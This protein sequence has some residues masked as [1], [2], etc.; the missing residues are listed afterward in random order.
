MKWSETKTLLTPL[1]MIT[2]VFAVSACG[3]SAT[4]DDSGVLP[5][6]S[7]EDCPDGLSCQA[8]V[9]AKDN[10]ECAFDSDCD[11]GKECVNGTC[12]QVQSDGGTDGGTDGGVDAGDQQQ[13][14]GIIEVDPVEID[15]GNG[16]IGDTVTQQLTI[17]N[18]GTADLRVF[19][20]TFESG[21][22][23]EFSAEPLGSVNQL[24]SPSD[25]L[26]V[27]V[28]Y[29]PTNASLDQGA[30]LIAC[31]DP[32]H[33]LVRVRLSSSYKGSSEITVTDD[34]SGDLAE[35]EL[36]D[37]GQVQVGSNSSDSV[38]VLNTGTGNAVLTIDEVRTQPISSEFFQLETN[39]LPPAYLNPFSGPC[40]SDQDC[41]DSNTC[42]SGLCVDQSGSLINAQS[43]QVTF[44]AT[45]VGTFQES[46]VITNDEAYGEG[47]ENIRIIT[48]RGEGVQPA[49]GV[50]PNPIDF[51]QLYTDES[52]DMDVVL[53]NNGGQALTIT[54]ISLQ[55]GTG[56]FDISLDGQSPWQL[57]PGQNMV[58]S[59]RFNPA[60]PGTYTD[61]LRIESDDP[62]SP[63]L[64]D[65]TGSAIFPPV[66]ALSPASLDFGEVQLGQ[67]LSLSFQ[68]S[69]DGGSP[70]QINSLSLANGSAG[71]SIAQQA[72]PQLDPGQSATVDVTYTPGGTIGADSDLLVISSN[73]PLSPD[74]TVNLTGLGTDPSLDVIP[75]SIDFGPIYQGYHAGPQIVTITNTGFGSLS[76]LSINLAVGSNPDYSLGNLPAMPIVLNSS[77]SIPVEVYFT[78]TASGLRTAAIEISSSDVD[79]PSANIPIAG[80]GSDCPEGY[81]DID[82]D[83]S[84]GCEY[85]CDLT[86]GGVEDC[87]GTDNDCDNQ[88]DEG[89][90]TRQ[91]EQTNTFGTC[92]GT[93]TCDGQHGWVGCDA[94]TPEQE[95]C[96][97]QDNDCD[98]AT[99]MEDNDLLAEPCELQQG[100]CTG[101]VHRVSLCVSGH[102]QSCEAIDYGSDYGAEQC[103]GMDND[104]DGLTD[105]ND[106][107]LVIPDCE[108]QNG[109]CSGSAKPLSLCHGQSG[110]GP[111]TQSEYSNYSPYYGTETCD[112]RDNDCDGFTDSADMDLLG[113][114]CENQ[115][116]QCAGAIHR[117]SLCTDGSWKPC[118][119]TDYQV[120]PDYGP[121]I[122]DGL[123]NNCQGGV[124]EGL[125]HD[126]A[127]RRTPLGPVMAPR[128]AMDKTDGLVATQPLQHKRHVMARIT[129]ATVQRMQMI[130]DSCHLL[131]S[132]KMEFVR[133]AHT[134]PVNAMVQDGIFAITPITR[135]MIPN[136]ELKFVATPWTK[137]AL[138]R[139]MTRIRMP[140]DT[141][142]WL[143]VETIA[144]TIILILIQ[145]PQRY[146]TWMIT[147]VMAWWTKD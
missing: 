44:T 65:V 117:T 98:N 127:S 3:S 68:V 74:V 79:R 131:V 121:E 67:D 115:D 116:G 108:N 25:D 96:D 73:D 136:L 147:T 92:F 83:P 30:L 144:T 49:L 129:T 64:V 87:D 38:Y 34:V 72:L 94:I 88:T 84:N 51:G 31:N 58:L 26:M 77:Q 75:D 50:L 66:I 133:A 113:T 106:G 80:S 111:C 4:P 128:H 91:C 71:F 138:E 40:A 23:D 82:H 1:P 90:T 97:G 105:V 28:N 35:V 17:R 56:P 85:Q 59:A 2:L 41:G 22:S 146:W 86:N 122:C 130:Q 47:D 89:L 95:V 19:S 61:T 55:D 142:M 43:I 126:N 141:R 33:A 112:G 12:Q 123:D 45:Q 7:T 110:W 24:L 63:T 8:G 53:S 139:R 10:P 60:D 125:V 37:F 101:A 39:P 137:T 114:L 27:S 36:I 32:D 124:D 99:D 57:E 132:F 107:D 76:L 100:V 134:A 18:T 78:P 15:F 119:D 135:R 13:G 120:D 145:E 143:A 9:C 6:I 29:S 62:D 109:V 69:N 14:Q 54:S 102:W 81:W 16:H 5:C 52:S 118:E 140:M 93:E 70:L 48:L 103:D 20:I 46:L 42:S 11:Q 21:S 104:C